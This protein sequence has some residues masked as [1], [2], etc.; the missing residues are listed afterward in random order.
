MELTKETIEF[1]KSSPTAF[2]AIYNMRSILLE[3]GFIEL[4]EEEPFSDLK[5]HQGYFVIRNSSSLIAFNYRKD[6]ANFIFALSHSDSPCLKLK[7]NPLTYSANVTLLRSEPYGGGIY[8]TF[9]DTPLNLSGRIVS[10]I[11]SGSEIELKTYIVDAN[12][13]LCFIPNLPIHFNRDVN[14]GYEY[15]PNKDLNAVL[16]SDK[17]E[18]FPNYLKEKFSIEGDIASFDLFLTNHVEPRLSGQN[19]EYILS[20]RLDNL[21][22]AF[23]SL[24]AFIDA[25]DASSCFPVYACFNNEEVGSLT[26]QGANSTFLKDI[27]NRIK[28]SLNLNDDKFLATLSSSF[29]LSI[30]NAH[31]INPNH[32]EIYDANPVY[33]GKGVVIKYNASEKYTSN[34]LS[35]SIFKSI[36]DKENI[37]YQEFTNRSDLPGGS[38]LGNLLQSIVSLKMIDIGIG[39]LAMHSS[40]ESA[41]VKD[42]D[43]MYKAVFACYKNKLPKLI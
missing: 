41:E 5:D 28:V 4:K 37:P 11:N 7:P 33:M 29:A 40:Y 2:N 17:I 18:S 39:Q 32:P 43:Y 25:K 36:L 21:T 16:S 3:H 12:E 8:S 24:K 42:L 38:T 10:K 34:A 35:A 6:Y 20:P 26:Y 27:L 23:L 1:I 31:A 13:D 14:K 30:D 9:L 15:N 22:S 19:R